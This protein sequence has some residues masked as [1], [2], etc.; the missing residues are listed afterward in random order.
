M[1]CLAGHKLIS[2]NI[3][4]KHFNYEVKNSLVNVTRLILSACGDKSKLLIC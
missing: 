2:S 1:T 3:D 4:C